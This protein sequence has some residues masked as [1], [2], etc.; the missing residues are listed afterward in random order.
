MA[1]GPV[2]LNY[3]LLV[4][5][6]IIWGSQFVLNEMIMESFPPLTVAAGRLGIGFI[7]LSLLL[8]IISRNRP[9]SNSRNQQPWRLYGAIAIFEGILPCFLIPWGQQRVD[10]SMAAILMATI[11][12]FT[13]VLAT[14][15]VRDEPW[16]LTSALAVVIGFGGVVILLGPKVQSNWFDNIIGELAILVGSLSFAISLI[17][18]RRLPPLP[19]VLTMRNVLFIAA[20]PMVALA[21]IVNRPW[22]LEVSW[23]SMLAILALG[24]FCGGI[25]YVM[26]TVLISRAGTTFT[27]LYNYLVVLVGV[28]IGMVVLGE[29]M[30]A[31]DIV[32]LL[33]ILFA[34]ALSQWNE[35]SR[36]KVAELESV[37]L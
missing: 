15:I 37:K 18:I 32:A 8:G 12:F 33:V 10:S 3:L 2:Q 20:I 22:E 11:P 30:T 17:L 9:R 13:L 28:F 23:T 21:C 26:L 4:G 25:V 1:Q 5:I 19:P 7:T 34:L 24:V 6:G 35:L 29:T 31:S 27:S 36:G 14:T 16:S